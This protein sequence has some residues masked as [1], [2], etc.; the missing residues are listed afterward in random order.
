MGKIIDLS[1]EF[2]PHPKEQSL[3][4]AKKKNPKRDRKA[5]KEF[6]KKNPWCIIRGCGRKATPNHIKTKGAGGANTEKNLR[7]LCAIHQTVRHQ[8]GIKS[9]ERKY[10]AD[11]KEWERTQK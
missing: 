2:H 9:F 6:L 11:I 3:C 7:P 4:R 8:M 5:I 10:R 1:K